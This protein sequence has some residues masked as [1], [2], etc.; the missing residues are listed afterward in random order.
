[1]HDEPY[2]F[3]SRARLWLALIFGV[4]ACASAGHRAMAGAELP[5]RASGA[6][7]ARAERE[8]PTGGA[9]IE[10]TYFSA[11][12]QINAENVQKLGFAWEYRTDS[13]RG[14]ESTPIVVGNVM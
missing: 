7:P 5:A 3:G 14:L 8:W 1:M 9:D 12:R 13:R 2:T 6:Q 4:I 10:G 11:L